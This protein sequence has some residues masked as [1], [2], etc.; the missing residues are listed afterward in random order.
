MALESYRP[1]ILR[2]YDITCHCNPQPDH[3]RGEA[4]PFRNGRPKRNVQSHRAFGSV[5]LGLER[6]EWNRETSIGYQAPRLRWTV[7]EER[8]LEYFGDGG[9]REGYSFR[10]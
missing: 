10:A 3:R 1:R 4:R 8:A 7:L 9:E 6:G 2:N 5:V